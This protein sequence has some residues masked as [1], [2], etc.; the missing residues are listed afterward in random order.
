MRAAVA[1]LVA[2]IAVARPAAAEPAGSRVLTAPT[3][4]LPRA[5][6]FA[7]M[8][9]IDHRGD[10][11]AVIGVGLG[12][13]AEL[14]LGSESDIRACTDCTA[15]PSP[16]WLGRATFRLG[17]RQ[18]AWFTGMPAV[19][20]GVRTTFAAR[21]HEVHE[22]RA[23]DAYVVASRDLGVVRLHAGLDAISAS[24]NGRRAAAHLRPHLRP[25]AGF[26]LHPPTYPR[27]SLLGDIAWEPRLDAQNENGPTFE[28]LLGIGVRYQAFP[29]ASV[30]LAVRARQAEDLGAS[31]VMI[32]VNAVLQ[33]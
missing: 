30:E 27:S 32:R 4:W 26:E 8:L 28:W 3:A 24:V 5:G 14:E 25:L 19:V 1:A 23:S 18:D 31:T 33:R 21:G 7:A 9:G 12:G 22:P 29:W 11:A 20:F 17:A 2:M 13:L 10:G 16:V 6:D 15:R